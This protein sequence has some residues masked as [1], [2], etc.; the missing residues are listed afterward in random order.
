ME[1]AYLR[2]MHTGHSYKLPEDSKIIIG[3]GEE[4]KFNISLPDPRFLKIGDATEKAK[5]VSRGRGHAKLVNLLNSRNIIVQDL[6][7]FN[8]T[9]INETR[10][11]SDT[12]LHANEGDKISL[13]DYEFMLITKHKLKDEEKKDLLKSDTQGPTH[14]EL[15]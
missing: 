12:P 2:D 13:G 1:S 5:T 14:F 11:Y 9:K 6:G 7:S 8:G 15:P 10:I 4:G 3:R